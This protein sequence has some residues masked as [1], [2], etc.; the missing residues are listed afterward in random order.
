M[1]KNLKDDVLRERLND[2]FYKKENKKYFYRILKNLEIK[3][4]TKYYNALKINFA[5]D[6]AFKAIV[7][8]TLL[9]KGSDFLN[10]N[11]L[12]FGNYFE[13]CDAFIFTVCSVIGQIYKNSKHLTVNAAF[14]NN[15]III[16]FIYKGKEV[17]PDIL[18]KNAKI[19]R[20]I[21]NN[22]NYINLKIKTDKNKKTAKSFKFNSLINNRMSALYTTLSFA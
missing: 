10:F 14:L 11:I 2:M 19:E 4:I 9:L 16:Q 17:N 3:R 7:Y 6:E 1:I 21:K 15:S 18:I 12:G 20:F 13:N 5:A 8:G 22:K